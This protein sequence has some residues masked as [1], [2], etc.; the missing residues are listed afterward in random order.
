MAKLI[1]T[2]EEDKI[3]FIH[4][5]DEDIGKLVKDLAL[6]VIG[7]SKAERSLYIQTAALIL[8]NAA[9]EMNSAE[10]SID[11]KNVKNNNTN[12]PIG[13]WSVTIRNIDGGPEI[14]IG[15][16]VPSQD[17]NVEITIVPNKKLTIEGT[18]DEAS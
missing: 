2:V 8:I 6:K 3:D 1:T 13:N 16:I 10:T 17:K 11:I 5:N 4:W 12:Q 15:E 14:S 18:D 7:S 9:H